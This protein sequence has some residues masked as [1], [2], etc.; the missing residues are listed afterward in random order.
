MD[1]V[2]WLDVEGSRCLRARGSIECSIQFLYPSTVPRHL[3]WTRTLVG[4][5]HD[6]TKTW[7][8][9][10]LAFYRYRIDANVEETEANVK[11]A[12]RELLKY[13]QSVTS[14]KWLIIKIFFVLIVFFYRICSIHG[15]NLQ[16]YIIWMIN[17]GHS[18]RFFWG[19]RSDGSQMNSDDR[20]TK[21]HNHK[22]IDN[23]WKRKESEN[24]CVTIA[25][26][27]WCNRQIF[28]VVSMFW[29]DMCHSLYKSLCIFT[30]L[31]SK[32]L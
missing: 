26:L 20:E 7:L 28:L 8:L 10:V 31:A 32:R 11:G 3:V 18:S 22:L 15:V 1:E 23:I 16:A 17:C 19:G 4:D 12:H 25:M 9:I 2:K 29:E 5:C 24:Q 14:N 30:R 6:Y 13:F 21:K 27:L